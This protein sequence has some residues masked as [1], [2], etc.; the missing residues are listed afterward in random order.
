MCRVSDAATIIVVNLYIRSFAKI[1]DVKM[2]RG[3]TRDSC[4]AAPYTILYKTKMPWPL[5]YL[6]AP[7]FCNKVHHSSENCK[8]PS[9]GLFGSQEEEEEGSPEICFPARAKNGV[10]S[11]F[12]PRRTSL[13]VEFFHF[14][15]LL[16]Y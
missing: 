5:F 15:P 13:R 9:L 16:V 4:S 8:S 12:P 11:N 6:L 3:N 10:T 7:F 2:V 1:D 14:P